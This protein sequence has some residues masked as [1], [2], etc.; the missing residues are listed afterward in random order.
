MKPIPNH[1]GYRITE[2][3]RVWSNKRHR[4]LKTRI[5]TNGYLS[6]N[7]PTEKGFRTVPIH[8]PL[9][10][11]FVGPSPEGMECRHLDG[12]RLNNSLNNLAWGTRSENQQ[13]AT[14]HG[15]RPGQKLNRLQVRVIHHLLES[16]EMTQAKI[17]RIFGLRGSSCIVNDIARGYSW[18]SVTGRVKI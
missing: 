18:S 6:V 16:G 12:N 11:T 7:F 17:S 2:D 13:D 5:D 3:G 9:L 1:P 8:R 14:L 15:T 4:W 10:E